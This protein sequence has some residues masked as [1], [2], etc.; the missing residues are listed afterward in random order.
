MLEVSKEVALRWQEVLAQHESLGGSGSK[1]TVSLDYLDAHHLEVKNFWVGSSVG[2]REK[3]L[4]QWM[5]FSKDWVIQTLLSLLRKNSFHRNRKL[6][7]QRACGQIGVGQ[8]L[9]E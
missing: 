1:I 8:V 6:F 3:L 9:Q 2:E 7:I 4:L 5:K